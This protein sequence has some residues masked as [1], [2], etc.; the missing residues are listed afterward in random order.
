MTDVIARV[1]LVALNLPYRSKVQFRSSQ[2]SNGAYSL[3]RLTTRDGAQGIAEVTGIAN[4]AASDPKHLADQFERV[5]Q[6]V[7]RGRRSVRSQPRCSARSTTFRARRS[8]RR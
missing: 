1:E 4:V 3:L 7:A 8:P 5:F 2:G 6:H